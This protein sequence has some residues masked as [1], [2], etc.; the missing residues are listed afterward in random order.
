MAYEISNK[1]SNNSAKLRKRIPMN[2]PKAP[3]K[4]E[5]KNDKVILGD[6]VVNVYDRSE[7]SIVNSVEQS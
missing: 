6:W 1:Y 5:I 4:L 3:P 2:K 7:N